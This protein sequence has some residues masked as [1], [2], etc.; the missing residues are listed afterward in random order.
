MT[1]DFAIVCQHCTEVIWASDDHVGMAV[2]CPGCHTALVVPTRSRAAKL[3]RVTE[4]VPRV[5]RPDQLEA[6]RNLDVSLLAYLQ[7]ATNKDCWE[8]GFL[9]KLLLLRMAPLQ[10]ALKQT[11]RRPKLRSRLRVRSGKGP[12]FAVFITQE[13]DRF[14]NLLGVIDNLL[15]DELANT[16]DRDDIPP[17]MEFA[18]RFGGLIYHLAG[19]AE[20]VYQMPTPREPP[21]PELMAIMQGWPGHCARTL[22]RLIAR[23]DAIYQSNGAD[24]AY[25]EFQ[26][27]LAPPDLHRF[28]VCKN[29]LPKRKVFHI[30]GGRPSFETEVE[31]EDENGNGN[32]G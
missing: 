4:A 14:F 28:F 7:K 21:C 25:F 19:W 9:A 2:A 18:N 24:L 12:D 22:S 32:G 31:I 8:Y 30:P 26:I 10:R 23:L 5:H 13:T 3:E 27:S 20:L 15:A 6:V 29:L 1:T 17:L 16:L 11:P